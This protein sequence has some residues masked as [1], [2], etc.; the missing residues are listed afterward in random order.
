M[1]LANFDDGTSIHSKRT[2]WDK[3]PPGKRMTG[4]QLS[5]PHLPKLYIC[6]ADL[7]KYYFTQEAIAFAQGNTPTVVAEIIGGH[8]LRLGVG[9]EVRLSYTGNVK[10]TH[11]SLAGGYKFSPNILYDGN[12]NG[13]APSLEIREVAE[14][15]QT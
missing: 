2:F 14:G 9:L 11:Y 3:V 6:L 7:D 8:D 12:G 15:A 13:R 1:W 5:H 4:I 10:I